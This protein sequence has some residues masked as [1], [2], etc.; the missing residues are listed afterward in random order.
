MTSIMMLVP[1]SGAALVRGVGNERQLAGA[2]QRDLQLALPL[3]ARA[4]ETARLD[5]AALGDELHQ[6]PHVLVVDVVDL[7]RPE[8]ADATAAK[9]APAAGRTPLST[10][11]RLR[12]RAALRTVHIASH[13]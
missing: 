9:A 5:L 3:G 7:L 12:C 13:D 10:F 2:L 6:Q 1:A 11:A 4:R 8:L